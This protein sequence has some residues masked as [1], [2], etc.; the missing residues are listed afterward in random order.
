MNNLKIPLKD[1][2]LALK[3]DYFTSPLM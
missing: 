2:P 1:L 3:T